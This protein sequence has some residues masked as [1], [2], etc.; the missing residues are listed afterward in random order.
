MIGG[1]MGIGLTAAAGALV[2]DQALKWLIIAAVMQPPRVLPVTPFFNLVLVFNKGISFGLFNTSAAANAWIFSGL[3]AVIIVFLLTWLRKA[4]GAWTAAALGLIIGGALG[5]VID[6]FSR[7]GVVDFLDFYVA[8]FHWPAFNAADSFIAVGAVF[9]IAESL[10][11]KKPAPDK[12][13][14]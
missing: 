5:N 11:S 12:M 2:I 3:A 7:G 4:E 9:L 8:D 14:D 1:R 6:R 13:A 10:F